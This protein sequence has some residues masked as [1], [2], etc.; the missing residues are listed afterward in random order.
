[1][2]MMEKIVVATPAEFDVIADVVIVVG[3][4]EAVEAEDAGVEEVLAVATLAVDVV[5]EDVDEPVTDVG[6]ARLEMKAI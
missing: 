3:V 1:M 6:G 4:G 5:L 2:V